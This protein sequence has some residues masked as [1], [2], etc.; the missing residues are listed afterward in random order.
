MKKLLLAIW[1][2]A[3]SYVNKICN[4]AAMAVQESNWRLLLLC[5][6]KLIGFVILLIAGLLLIVMLLYA[7]SQ[8]ATS[9]WNHHPTFGFVHHEYPQRGRYIWL[10]WCTEFYRSGNR[11]GTSQRT[12]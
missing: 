1:N 2:A 8:G 6:A 3:N 4:E 5:I 9:C 10:R 7:G 11:P 12:I